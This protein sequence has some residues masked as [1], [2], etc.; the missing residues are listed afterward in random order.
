MKADVVRF[1]PFELNTRTGELRKNGRRL[2]LSPQPGRLLC[3][4]TFR[5][6][7]L[8]T[9]DEIRR[10]LWAEEVFVDFDLALN[11]CLA[12]LRSIL[13]DRARAPRYIETLPRRGYRFI[14][15]VE[16]PRLFPQPTIAVLP[17]TNLGGDPSLTYFAD[18]MTDALITELACISGL[19]VISRQTVL[20]LK[21]SDKPLP[22]IARELGVDA[23]VEG[24]ALHTRTAIRITVQLVAVAPERHLW[25][26]AYECAPSDIVSIH[27]Q[28]A[29]AVAE[30]VD[31]ALTPSELARLS[32]PAP[33]HPGA[34]DAYLKGLFHGS[35]EQGGVEQGRRLLRRSD[36]HRSNL[37]S[38]PRGAR[39]TVQHARVLGPSASGAGVPS[40]EGGGVDGTRSRRQ[41]CSRAFPA[42]V[43]ELV[44]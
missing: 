3:L 2:A 41:L 37:R 22:A 13:G 19:R 39:G 21:G 43:G 17:F 5:A 31:A 38:C 16:R 25:A 1:G 32:R 20:H 4:L 12:H 26:H 36:R 42:R 6:D 34:H 18:G 44:V 9:R 23:V 15:P 10:H 24:T 27:R 40:R 11:S 33:V 35:T 29:R 30:G 8:V 14:A 7:D 28:V